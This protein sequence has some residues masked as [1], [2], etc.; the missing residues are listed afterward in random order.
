MPWYH[1]VLV[2]NPLCA[3]KTFVEVRLGKLTYICITSSTML[4]L[5]G[6]TMV[7]SSLIRLGLPHKQV[8]YHLAS[9]AWDGSF[10][11]FF[12]DELYINIISLRIFSSICL[13]E[14]ASCSPGCHSVCVRA[15]VCVCVRACACVGP[16]L[17]DIQPALAS[18][19]GT[20][21]SLITDFSISL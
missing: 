10:Q 13:Q 11:Y 21:K 4:T 15:C 3:C 1:Y 6:R 2:L 12:W 8:D 7:F 20:S 19:W 14:P 9:M 16:T 18:L 5:E 17:R